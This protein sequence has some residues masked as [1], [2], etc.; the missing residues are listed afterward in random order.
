MS[1]LSTLRQIERKLWEGIWTT[2]EICRVHQVTD[3]TLRRWM[4]VLRE[5][6]GRYNPRE[7]TRGSARVYLWMCSRPVFWHDDNWP[8][9]VRP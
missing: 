5:A 7:S 6:G 3:R 2:E 1:D 9:V 4:A 8:G